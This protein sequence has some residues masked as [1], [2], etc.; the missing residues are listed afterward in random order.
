MW[1]EVTPV[2]WL[3]DEKTGLAITKKCILG[4]IPLSRKGIFLGDFEKT[5][6]QDFIDNEF[7]YDVNKKILDSSNIFEGYDFID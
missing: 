3:V 2:E 1:V 4:G 5:L 7:S 6:V